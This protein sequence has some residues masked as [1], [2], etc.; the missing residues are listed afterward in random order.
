MPVTID[1]TTL[2]QP[3]GSNVIV[4]VHPSDEP[5]IGKLIMPGKYSDRLAYATIM[6][7]GPGEADFAGQYSTRDLTVGDVVLVQ[8]KANQPDEMAP[9]GQSIQPV[10]MPMQVSG[11]EMQMVPSEMILLIVSKKSGSGTTHTSLN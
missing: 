1:L 11:I 3:R 2:P 6:A 9:R 8:N 5:K 4:R 7:V 10:G